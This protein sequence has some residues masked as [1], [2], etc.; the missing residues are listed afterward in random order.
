MVQSSRCDVPVMDA[1][2][3]DGEQ[4]DEGGLGPP[5]GLQFANR[6]GEGL[7]HLIKKVE[8]GRGVPW[9]IEA[10]HSQRVQSWRAVY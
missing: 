1:V 7:E 9:A 2:A 3:L 8:T 6:E 5:V 4:G 10:E